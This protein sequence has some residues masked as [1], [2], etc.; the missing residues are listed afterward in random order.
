MFPLQHGNIVTSRLKLMAITPSLL[1]SEQV[2]DGRLGELMGCAVPANWLPEHWEPHVHEVLLRQYEH[3]PEHVSWQRYVGLL[4][5]GEMPLLIGT[6]GAFWR[7]ETRAECEMGWS[8]VPPYEG[9]GFATEAVLALI[10]LIRQ[11]PR[12]THVVAHTFPEVIGSVRVMMKCGFQLR[13]LERRW[14]RCGIGCV[15]ESE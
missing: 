3:C 5:P 4:R 12:M 9:R 10:G 14:E 7:A 15:C 1:R 13:E 2:E 11:D 8:I 6:V